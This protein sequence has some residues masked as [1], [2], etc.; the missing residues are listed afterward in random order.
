LPIDFSSLRQSELFGSAN[1]LD[2]T[3]TPIGSHKTSGQ[4]A[5][6]MEMAVAENRAK[7][8]ENTQNVF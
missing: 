2:D 3:P 6:L 5:A 7:A 1:V 4:G 8:E